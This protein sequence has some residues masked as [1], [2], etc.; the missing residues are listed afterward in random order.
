MSGASLGPI[1][2]RFISWDGRTPPHFERG[3]GA[4]GKS[5]KKTR[6]P[7]LDQKIES[8]SSSIAPYKE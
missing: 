2:A 1:L 7:K 6:L 8:K 5:H 3:T 4:V